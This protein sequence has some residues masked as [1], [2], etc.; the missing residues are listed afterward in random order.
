MSIVS[1]SKVM[2]H[3]EYD[4]EVAKGKEV[5][6]VLPFSSAS[7]IFRINKCLHL[8]AGEARKNISL[9]GPNIMPCNWKFV[10]EEPQWVP[11]SPNNKGSKMGQVKRVVQVEG[12][13]A[14]ACAP[15]IST[16]MLVCQVCSFTY[17]TFLSSK[18]T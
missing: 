15:S 11:T 6:P 14:F 18:C 9:N 13:L 16:K 7:I 5:F 17:P 2:K 1:L 10:A 4:A 8:H 12:A 3:S